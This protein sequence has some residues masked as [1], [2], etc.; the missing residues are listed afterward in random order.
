VVEG[1]ASPVRDAT[2]LQQLAEG[3]ATKYGW[4][5]TVRGNDFIGEEGNVAEVYEV[6]P[7]TVFAFGKGTTFSQTRWRW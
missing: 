1:D 2:K 4:R 7:T 5:F 3:W 6:T